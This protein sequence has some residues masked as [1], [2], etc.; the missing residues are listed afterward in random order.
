VAC[1]KHTDRQCTTCEHQCGVGTEPV[2]CPTLNLNPSNGCAACD[3]TLKPSNSFYVLSSVD[4]LTIGPFCTWYFPA[5]PAQTNLS[6]SSNNYF[7]SDLET[8]YSYSG[9]VTRA[10]SAH[11]TRRIRVVL[12][13]LPARCATRP[14][15]RLGWWREVVRL[16]KTLHVVSRV[17]TLPSLHSTRSG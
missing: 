8:L 6:L 15:A 17:L 10:S 4:N 5:I 14:T 2:S 13:A 9:S 3:A 12:R 11:W 1:G 16:Y 7:F